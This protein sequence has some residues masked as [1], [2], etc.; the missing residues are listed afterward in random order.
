VES[1]GGGEWLHAILHPVQEN[2]PSG[3][4]VGQVIIVV[5]IF[6]VHQVLPRPLLKPPLWEGKVRGQSCYEAAIF[7]LNFYL[8]DAFI[9]KDLHRV[10]RQVIKQQVGVRQ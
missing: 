3:L 6:V 4:H 10:L 5:V 2:L 8:A 1:G 9:E 7:C